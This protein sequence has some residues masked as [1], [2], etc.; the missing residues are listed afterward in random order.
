MGGCQWWHALL[1]GRPLRAARQ[2]QQPRLFAGD[3]RSAGNAMS[4]SAT[5]QAP[6]GGPTF[7]ADLLSSGD[8][9]AWSLALL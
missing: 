3:E 7:K 2:Q 4:D 9:T 5:L 8:S 6:Q 1:R